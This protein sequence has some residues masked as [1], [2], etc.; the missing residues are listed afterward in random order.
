MKRTSTALKIFL[1]SIAC[2]LLMFAPSAHAAGED[3][4]LGIWNDEEKDAQI[5]I[6]RCGV[7]YCGKIVWI[8]KPFYSA[9]EDRTK[10]GLPRTD[11]NNPNS[12]LRSHPII[13][14]Q[15]MSGFEYAEGYS[16]V[17]GKLY[18]PKSGMTYSGKMTLVS[19]DRLELRGYVIFSLFGR[20]SS[21]S[22]VRPRSLQDSFS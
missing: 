6:F 15:I 8:N 4:I 10:A 17:G 7:K 16:W 22:R 20:T 19:S 9:D 2:I 11:D 1:T 18:D 13:G 3:R 12:D 21:W 14:L 5:E